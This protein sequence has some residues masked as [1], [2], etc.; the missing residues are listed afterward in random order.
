MS[1]LD[2]LTNKNS[3]EDDKNWTYRMLIIGPS[4]SGKTNALLNLIQKQNKYNPTDKIY[5]YAKN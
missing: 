1:D 3:K 2:A 5:L 4:E